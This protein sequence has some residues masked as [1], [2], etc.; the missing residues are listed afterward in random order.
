MGIEKYRLTDEEMSK[1]RDKHYQE[2]GEVLGLGI[3][4]DIADAQIAKVLRIQAEATPEK[5]REEI[6]ATLAKYISDAKCQVFHSHDDVFLTNQILSVVQPLIEQAK[7]DCEIEKQ[8]LQE[9]LYETVEQ[10]KR[11]ERK[12]MLGQLIVESVIRNKVDI[13]DKKRKPFRKVDKPVEWWQS[14]QDKES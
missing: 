14:I 6:T 13:K 7:A 9:Q 11:E 4:A 12:I 2:T 8:M 5:V 10:A 1:V 3:E